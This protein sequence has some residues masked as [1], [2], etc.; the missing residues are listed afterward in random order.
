MIGPVEHNP[1]IEGGARS[2]DP[3]PAIY[4][5]SKTPLTTTY[6]LGQRGIGGGRGLLGHLVEEGQELRA[7]IP[8]LGDA[9]DDCWQV[10]VCACTP[11]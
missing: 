8:G 5:P 7:L 3:S 10:Q 2:T 9:V 6:A 1:N 11:V 4:H